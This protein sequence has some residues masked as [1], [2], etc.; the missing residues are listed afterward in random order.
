MCIN[1]CVRHCHNETCFM[2]TENSVGLE[3]GWV[4]KML[5]QTWGPEFEYTGK[6]AQECACLWFQYYQDKVGDRRISRISLPAS[7][8]CATREPP[9]LS[10]TGWKVRINNRGCSHIL[11]ALL[12]Y[13][14]HV[15]THVHTHMHIHYMHVICT[16]K[17][18]DFLK[19]FVCPLR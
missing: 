9:K 4:N 18:N 5:M 6:A 16:H 8:T 7:L 15:C 14:L 17:N 10:Q 2:L 11:H 3:G 12:I 19:I 13:S 1:V